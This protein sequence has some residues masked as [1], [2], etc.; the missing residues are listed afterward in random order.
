MIE[1]NKKEKFSH[2]YFMNRFS[3]TILCVCLKTFC[4]HLLFLTIFKRRSFHKKH[5][6]LTCYQFRWCHNRSLLRLSMYA[7]SYASMQFSYPSTNI[8]LH[9]SIS[10]SPFPSFLY[11]L[12]GKIEKFFPHLQKEK[13]A[14]SLRF[15]NC[16]P[17]FF[18]NN[19][20][21][22]PPFFIKYSSYI[23]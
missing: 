3:S 11:F 19:T 21:H 22:W 12:K 4:P 6:Q 13:K 7:L 17:L 1:K 23:D 14:I 9:L 15:R 20:I 2:F 10:F 16:P 18:S 8:D 5:P